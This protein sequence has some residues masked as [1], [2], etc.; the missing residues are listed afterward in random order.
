MNK[1]TIAALIGVLVVSLAGA[2][3]FA[4][5]AMNPDQSGA[6]CPAW[7]PNSQQVNLTEE[8]KAQ[9]ETWRQE[10]L[11]HRKQVLQKQVEWGWLTQEQAD[12][13]INWL[14]QHHRD[15]NFRG[16]GMMGHGK[17]MGS[18]HM[19]GGCGNYSAPGSAQ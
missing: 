17:G 15:G 18:M 4:A 9:I 5:P 12:Q 19:Q 7:G 10:G 8:Q 2:V 13:Q 3:A 1:T 16:P 6:F 14:E 11:E